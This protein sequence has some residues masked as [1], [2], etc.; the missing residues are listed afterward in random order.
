MATIEETA[1]AIPILVD[2]PATKP[3]LQAEVVEATP[4]VT[5]SQIN[6]PH[7]NLTLEDRH[8]D[9]LR[10]L[11][12]G[13]IGAG[14]S[15]VLA[16]IL[17]PAKVPE[18]QLTIFEK[19]ED[20]GGTWLENQYPGVRCDIPSHVY[21]ATFSP[22]TQW[23]EEFAEG[24]EIW[25]YW[26][27]QARKYD[28]YRY[29]KFNSN[30]QTAQ[31]DDKSSKWVLQVEDTKSA[32]TSHEEFDFILS[33]IGRFNAWRL[34]KYEGIEEYQGHLRHT[35][36]WDSSFDVTGK[37]VA[38]I[39]NGA[40]GIQLVPNIQP[41]V[42][43]LDHYARSKTWIA[44]TWVGNERVFGPQPFSSDTLQS[45]QDPQ[46]YLKYRKEAEGTYW[47]GIK[48]MRRESAEVNAMRDDYIGIMKKRLKKK[49]ELLSRLIP[50][51][52]P[53]CRRLT[54]GPGYLEAITEDNVDYIQ[55]PIRRLT[56]TGI[57]TIDGHHREVDAIFCATGFN[58]DFAPPFPIQARGV[59]LNKAWKPDGEVGYPKTY[60]GLAAPGFPNL[61]FVGGPHAT[62][63]SGTVPHSVENQL[64]YYAKI[65]RKV[66][67]QGIKSIAPSS[68]AV[69][70]FI[71]YADAYFPTT[72]LTDNCSS[73]AN[74][75][76]PGAR[77]HGAWP[78]SASHQ[79][80]IRR[81]PRWE[82]WE[83]EY[84]SPS[85]NR[86]AYFGNGRTTRELDP[87]TDMTRY[88]TL[89]SEVD[90]RNIHESWWQWP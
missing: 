26:Q 81:E 23:T 77:I 64:T 15:G 51:F 84:L 1:Q 82:D 20:V 41:L 86:Y 88:L 33:A 69:D 62:G 42:K 16:G 4:S 63:A 46:A 21:Q 57:E 72:P 50:D 10:P 40:S 17:L 35:S 12:V 25:N 53:H 27:Y 38:V 43:R 70:E 8:V 31:W 65:L 44:G 32:T 34:P 49:P 13:V 60:L 68:K 7:S 87:D 3:K 74:G 56:K 52:S 61:L 59:D 9:E 89:P 73:W 48:A 80:F 54:P 6:Y 36:N 67:S 28:V 14:L 39:G 19:N 76:R 45:F 29:I 5:R 90:L 75:G 37:S 83:Y 55:T 30:I 2:E 22:N 78:G 71:E 66:S 79:T 18:I 24:K 58:I 11:K 47:R 85:G